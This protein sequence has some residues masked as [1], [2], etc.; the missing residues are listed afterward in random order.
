MTLLV[1]INFVSYK[2]GK[3]VV[4]CNIRLETQIFAFFELI[5]SDRD[6]FVSIYTVKSLEITDAL[7]KIAYRMPNNSGKTFVFGM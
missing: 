5:G 3:C 6:I 7:P 4:G 1:L 2:S